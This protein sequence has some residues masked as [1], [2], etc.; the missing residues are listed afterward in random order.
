[1]L[2]PVALGPSHNVTAY[3][4]MPVVTVP[5]VLALHVRD[6]ALT[7]LAPSVVVV[8]FARL[9]ATVAEGTEAPHILNGW[10]K[11]W[12]QYH[13]VQVLYGG[14]VELHQGDLIV[15]RIVLDGIRRRVLLDNF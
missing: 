8:A 10:L 3:S 15:P 14:H 5:A 4:T 7:P 1:M 11:H 9:P 6:A 13:P 12:G 2:W